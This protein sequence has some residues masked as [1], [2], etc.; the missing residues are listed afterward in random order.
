MIP[1]SLYS[2]LPAAEKPFWHSHVFEVQ[3][4]M[5]V[6]PNPSLTALPGTREAWEAAE[7]R[8]MR[9]VVEL[10]GKVFHTWQTDLG[11]ALPLGKPQLMTSFT[12]E[13]QFGDFERLVGERDK[14][15]ETDWKRAKGLRSGIE[16]MKVDPA[17]DGAWT[18]RG[19]V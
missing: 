5:L 16:G 9:H 2:T 18:R 7:T 6:M 4:G 15:F 1:P 10:Y 11:H 17:A 14:K 3:S 8:E 12:E 13:G 19:S